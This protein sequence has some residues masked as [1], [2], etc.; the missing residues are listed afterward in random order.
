[1]IMGDMSFKIIFLATLLFALAIFVACSTKSGQGEKQRKLVTS[2]EAEGGSFFGNVKATTGKESYS[3]DGFVTGFEQDEDS[4]EVAFS[5]PKDG[6]Y[7]LAFLIQS[8]G[9]HKENFVFV[10]GV[11][12]GSVTCDS[13][14]VEE[15]SLNRVFL[16]AGKHKVKLKK[17]WG[18]INWDKLE[19]YESAPLP[20]DLYQASAKLSNPNASDNAKRVMTTTGKAFCQVNMRMAAMPAGRSSSSRKTTAERNLP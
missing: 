16:S 8:K 14:K 3:G 11:Q 12:Q 17:S 18:W 10:D 7:D 6:F 19:V 4:C 13:G 15:A 2:V 9:G 5:V 1:M 20:K